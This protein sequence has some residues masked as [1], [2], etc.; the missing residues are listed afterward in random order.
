MTGNDTAN[1]IHVRHFDGST[2]QYLHLRKNG[3]S[4]INPGLPRTVAAGEPLHV[5]AGQRL[6]AAGNVGISMFA[7]LHFTVDRPPGSPEPTDV[8]DRRPVKFQDADTASHGNRCFSMRKYVSSNLDRGRVVVTA[9]R[10][11]LDPGG[12]PTDGSEYPRRASAAGGGGTALPPAPPT[13][14]TGAPAGAP[15]PLT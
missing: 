8:G 7:H 14:P 5:Y 1:E 10:P 4:E 12:D 3:V 13:P 15:S 9:D 6:A 2:A 11:S